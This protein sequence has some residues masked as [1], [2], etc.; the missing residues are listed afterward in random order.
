MKIYSRLAYEIYVFFSAS[1]DATVR[2]WDVER[3]VCLRSLCR[4]QE[5]VYSVA[6]SPD[7]KLLAS[8]SFDKCVY[9]WDTKVV[10]TRL[11]S[12]RNESCCISTFFFYL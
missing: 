11:V 1:F 9:I 8:G 10:R 3:G 12:S 2:L 7:G 6:F 5:P 4:H